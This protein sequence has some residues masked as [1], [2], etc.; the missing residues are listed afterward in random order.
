MPVLFPF[1]PYDHAETPLSY[2]TR[3][4]AM[5]LG[6]SVGPFL[7]DIGTKA[8]ALLRCEGEALD[9]LADV[10]GVDVTDFHRNSVRNLG[11]RQFD[12]RGNVFSAEFL[13]SPH[14]VF[15]PACLRE[16]NACGTDPARNWRGRLIWTLGPVR[17]CPSHELIL[18]RRRKAGWD[19]KYRQLAAIVPLDGNELN[20]LIDGGEH[21]PVSPLQNYVIERLEGAKGPA[22]LDDQSLEQA[23]RATE[24]LGVLLEFGP[25]A[26]PGDLDE[27]QWDAAGRAGFAATSNG[28][29]GIRDALQAV[30]G[31][32]LKQGGKPDRG[33]VLGAPYRWLASRKNTKDPG[34]I[35]RVMRE[36]IFATLEVAEGKPILGEAL[37]KRRLH[38]VESLASEANL[39]PRTLRNILAAK[40][41]VPV[42]DKVIGHHVFDA[43][44]GR[45]IAALVKRSTTIKSLPEALNCTRPQA[46]QLVDEGMLDPIADGRSE[47]AGRTRKAINDQDIAR[48]IVALHGCARV[49]DE[50]PQGMVSI[51][52]A[53]EKAKVTSIEVIHLVLG[54]F[55][56]NVLRLR[57][58]DGYAAIH[59]DPDEL[60]I[61]K[62]MHLPGMSA[63]DA[64]ARLKLPKSSGWALMNREDNPR[65]RPITIEG[66]NGEH[67][68]FRFAEEQ[69]TA[70]A[71]E[72]VTEVRI[73]NI[74]GLEKKDVRM[75]LKKR[76]LRPVLSYIELGLNL[77]R[78][79]DIP[80]LEPV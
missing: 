30:Q 72:Y 7:S 31:D 42:Q 73:A 64:F 10:T 44:A 57:G 77:Y 47:A 33:N 20:R 60:K 13:S 79:T 74:L 76:G 35:R 62:A 59:V 36:H 24:M 68:F 41:I 52:K 22:W 1:L 70:F 39:D 49:V 12:L 5:H 4:A 78:A 53:A 8:D 37:P 15:C 29:N 69:V 23:V 11:G 65:L 66:R 80:L 75:R 48:F 2:A 67:R 16:D 50:V 40:G 9:R 63:S 56:Q 19:N 54:G 51:A 6:S 3:L 45:Q 27:D 38:S 55:L 14:T 71:S 17:T 43:D 32:Y 21:R 34:D 46:G 26:K 61:L 18:V 58:V 25:K 28:E